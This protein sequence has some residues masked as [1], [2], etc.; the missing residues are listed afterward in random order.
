MPMDHI[1]LAHALQHH[2]HL[3][4]TLGEAEE[5][6][7]PAPLEVSSPAKPLDRHRVLVAPPGFISQKKRDQK[8]TRKQVSG[9]S[10]LVVS[11]RPSQSTD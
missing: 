4:S 5:L 10:K 7:E 11:A 6:K 8:A 3:L 9:Q 2:A 1:E